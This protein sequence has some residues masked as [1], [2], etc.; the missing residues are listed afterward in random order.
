MGRAADHLYAQVIPKKG[1]KENPIA[2]DEFEEIWGAPGSAKRRELLK[3]APPPPPPDVIFIRSR[4]ARKSVNDNST[5]QPTPVTAETNVQGKTMEPASKNATPPKRPKKTLK[6]QLKTKTSTKR[7]AGQGDDD[8][9]HISDS[10][11][12][13]DDSVAT[14]H[15]SK[16]RQA[17]AAPVKRLRANAEPKYPVRAMD[18]LL[19]RVKD[20]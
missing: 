3:P 19:A 14:A 11:V 13:D 5:A 10:D 4:K 12:M 1:S 20:N 2:P 17:K 18:H 7:R 6:K 16:R 15:K 9:D 8:Y